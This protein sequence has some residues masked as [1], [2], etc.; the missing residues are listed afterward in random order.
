MLTLDVTR[1]LQKFRRET[2][3]RDS[4]IDTYLDPH[5]LPRL[6]REVPRSPLD[7][8]FRRDTLDFDMNYKYTTIGII[9]PRGAEESWMKA[10]YMGTYST[11]VDYGDGNDYSVIHWPPNVNADFSR[12][13]E[14]VDANWSFAEAVKAQLQIDDN[15]RNN[16]LKR[17]THESLEHQWK[18]VDMK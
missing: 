3:I 4:K 7:L 14:Y 9:V 5:S 17:M 18:P 10:P 1:A 15:R 13:E 2:G 16:E 12:K 11:A 6:D 8:S